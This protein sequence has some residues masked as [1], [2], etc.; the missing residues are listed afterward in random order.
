MDDPSWLLTRVRDV[1]DFPTPGILFKDLTPLL[2]DP[3]AFRSTV[4][5]LAAYSRSLDAPV[6][7]VVGVEARGFTFAAGVAYTLGAGLVPVRKPGKLPHE[8]VAETYALEYGTDTLEMHRD[9]VGE[10][11]SV[12]VVDDVLATGGTAA[13]TCRLLES[14]GGRVAGLAFVLELGFLDGRAKLPD[15]DIFSLLTT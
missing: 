12:L 9:A 11:E 10:G 3:A 15:Y 8:T 13:A 5:A 1:P 7:K 6:T 14:V 2:G 4:D